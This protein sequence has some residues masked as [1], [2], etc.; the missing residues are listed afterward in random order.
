M[1]KIVVEKSANVELLNERLA[2]R[3][4]ELEVSNNKID[5]LN[6]RVQELDNER[7]TAETRATDMNNMNR[8]LNKAVQKMKDSLSKKEQ[9]Q[10]YFAHWK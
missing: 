4:N 1:K 3:T 9:V 5:M 2:Q 10:R 7:L 6:R 8:E